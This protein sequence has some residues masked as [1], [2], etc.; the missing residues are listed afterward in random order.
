MLRRDMPQMRAAAD[1]AARL[2]E[3]LA[4]VLPLDAVDGFA[5]HLRQRPVE[6]DVER[7]P[8]RRRRQ[9]F[10]R[11]VL[12]LEHA[13][14][15]GD[16]GPFDGVLQLADV[17]RPAVVEQHLH[18]SRRNLPGDVAG[19]RAF[20]DEM[21]RQKRNILRPFAQRRQVDLHHV[22]AVIEVLAERPLGD[23]AFEVAVG[24]GDDAHVHL[25][26]LRAADALETPLLEYAQQLGLHGQRHVADLVE[27]NGAA[28]GHLEAA[29][30]LADGAGEGALL[31]AEQLALQKGFGQGGAVDG[32]ERA[33][34]I[35]RRLVDGAA[36]S[37]PCR[38]PFRPRSAPSCWYRRGC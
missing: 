18:R 33:G 25:D 27:E 16:A 13:V 34:T 17:A 12:H 35:L 37:A 9:Q 19:P 15:R 30:A 11:Q 6:V 29:A 32:H 5:Q 28:V 14:A 31:V 23:Q 8:R 7:R 4:D 3:R 20:V 36:P 1:V 38:C 21:G 26:A 10:R 2:L 24:G 22:E